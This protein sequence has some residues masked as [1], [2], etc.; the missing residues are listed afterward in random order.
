MHELEAALQHYVDFGDQESL[1]KYLKGFSGGDAESGKQEEAKK[2]ESK[3]DEGTKK[4]DEAA[5]TAPATPA[6]ATAP[7][8]APAPKAGNHSNSG[9]EANS[10]DKNEGQHDDC[11]DNEEEEE[12]QSDAKK[13]QQQQKQGS[14]DAT[15]QPEKPQ[16]PQQPEKPVGYAPDN[17]TKKDHNDD[18]PS[19]P[20][21][22]SS[23][24]SGNSING[25]T[26]HPSPSSH[27]P[28]HSHPLL[29]QQPTL[30]RH[31]TF[32]TTGLGACG[33]TNTDNQ[34]IVA[35][36]RDLF[37]QFNP[38]SGNPNYNSLC[39]KK[40]EITW[41]GKTVQAFAMDECPGCKE[42]SLDLSPSVFEKLDAK[43]KG[44]LDGI[45]WRFI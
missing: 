5:T 36:S 1:Q 17:G 18:H 4:K 39:G 26:P 34:P 22:G 8:S 25:Y 16:Q 7:V 11:E 35:V 10:G 29:S 20:S 3:K 27:L 38:S 15:A 43:D 12:K 37:E 23:G 2:D 19:S 32:Y 13:E 40:L 31:A 33:I 21:P 45:S 24:S 9:A 42:V 44:V 6:P 14:N 41:K 28:L 30:H